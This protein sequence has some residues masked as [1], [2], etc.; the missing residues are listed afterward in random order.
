MEWG[1]RPDETADEAADK[2]GEP[3]REENDLLSSTFLP[4]LTSPPPFPSKNPP[5]SLVECSRRSHASSFEGVALTSL[6]KL[7]YYVTLTCVILTTFLAVGGYAV[8][9]RDLVS[10][11][12]ARFIP[13]VAVR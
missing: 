7:G 5:I 11:L 13:D 4:N 1:D 12:W 2:V 3:E 9:L 8:L 6:G 10:P